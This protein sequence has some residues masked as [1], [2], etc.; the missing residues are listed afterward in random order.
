MKQDILQHLRHGKRQAITGERLAKLLGQRN[1]RQ[2][3]CLIREL[4]EEGKPI[5]SSVHPPYG[6]YLVET[7]AEYEEYNA[8]LRARAI[9][10]FSRMMAFKKAA[11]GI[12]EGRQLMMEV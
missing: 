4:I 12:F 6:Y 8:V 5:A 10:N 3:R 2:I 7:V 1:D 9:D 11:V